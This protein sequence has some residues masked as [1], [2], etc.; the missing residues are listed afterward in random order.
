MS[1]NNIE[2]N[3][4]SFLKAGSQAGRI[5]GPGIQ[6][7]MSSDAKAAGKVVIQYDW[8]MSNGQIGDVIAARQWLL[9]GSRPRGRVQPGRT[10]CRDRAAGDVRRRSARPVLRDAAALMPR[11]PAACRSRSSPA[12]FAPGP[13]R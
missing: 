12:A 8:L 1:G 4:R 11:A 10:Q 3:R 13:M 6:L 5:F 9:Q 2:F 7:V